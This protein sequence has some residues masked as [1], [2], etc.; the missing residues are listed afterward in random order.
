MPTKDNVN[1][2][3][4]CDLENAACVRIRPSIVREMRDK[5]KSR[6]AR[7][8]TSALAARVRA[9]GRSQFP[10]REDDLFSSTRALR[11]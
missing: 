4:L 6:A 7:F 5:R 3:R 8:P 10:R 11:P 1:V 9:N 2:K